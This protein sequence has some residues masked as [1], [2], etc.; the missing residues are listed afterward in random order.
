MT[1]MIIPI[2]LLCIIVIGALSRV[3]IF[4]LFAEGVKEGL[5]TIFNLFPIFLG[6][7]L[8]VSIFRA[9]GLI[10]IFSGIMRPILELF[11][12]PIEL[13]SLIML[14][15]VSGSASLAVFSEIVKESNSMSFISFNAAIIMG[16]TETLMY[17]IAVYSGSINKKMSYKVIILAILGNIL[18]II[19][20]SFF[21]R[22]F[23]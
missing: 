4:E 5:Y 21:A 7:F 10:F 14:K 12:V 1:S 19:L 8:A 3:N 20:G 16:S 13:I 22:I 9:S 15:P 17:A 23:F 18:S 2:M 6:L 11:K